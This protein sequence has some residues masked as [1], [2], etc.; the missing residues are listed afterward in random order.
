[1]MPKKR[2]K[3]NPSFLSFLLAKVFEWKRKRGFN[4]HLK[5]EKKYFGQKLDKSEEW[6]ISA[7]A[8]A[9]AFLFV[10]I[11]FRFNQR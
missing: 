9:V 11:T 4:F 10:K 2:T 3:E 6:N 1:M 8:L 7:S 5:N